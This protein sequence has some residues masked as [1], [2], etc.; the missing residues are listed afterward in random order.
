MDV[1]TLH[2]PRGEIQA[3]IALWC[4]VEISWG[5]IRA[6]TFFQ[7]LKPMVNC[8]LTW[9]NNLQ[10]VHIIVLVDSEN[11]SQNRLMDSP[12]GMMREKNDL[13]KHLFCDPDKITVLFKSI[14]SIFR[15]KS[16]VVYV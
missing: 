15:G 2:I 13:V 7:S 16:L 3:D 9:E 14:L 4:E 8:N 1:C 12:F 5:T 10:A 11:D 6:C